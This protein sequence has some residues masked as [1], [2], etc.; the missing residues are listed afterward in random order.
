[1]A[2]TESKEFKSVAIPLCGYV[3]PT[4]KFS[5]EI[6]NDMLQLLNGPSN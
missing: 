1:M 5:N 2:I 4:F 3:S 6:N